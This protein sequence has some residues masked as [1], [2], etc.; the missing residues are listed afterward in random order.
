MGV[1]KKLVTPMANIAI[2][3]DRMFRAKP[4][5]CTFPNAV[6]GPEVG[7]KNSTLCLRHRVSCEAPA[8]HLASSAV[9]PGLPPLESRSANRPDGRSQP[10]PSK[11]GVERESHSIPDSFRLPSTPCR[12]HKYQS[13]IPQAC[14]DRTDLPRPGIVGHCLRSNGST[15]DHTRQPHDRTDGCV[16]SLE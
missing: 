13:R 12:G 15:G 10:A 8:A 6:P 14:C 7:I 16:A 9:D 2:Q 3:L 1:R 11:A 4:V 5:F